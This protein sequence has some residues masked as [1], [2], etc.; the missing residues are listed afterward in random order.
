M[1][2][3]L[4]DID[5]PLYRIAFPVV[6]YAIVAAN[7]AVFGL[8]WLLP[9]QD[10]AALAVALAFQPEG[11]PPGVTAELPFAL[12]EPVGAL[13]ALFVQRDLWH[14]VGNMACLIVFAD[15]VEDAMG[16]LKFLA[17]YLVVGFASSYG[18]ALALE[19]QTVLYGSSGAVSGVIAAYVMLHPNVRLWVLVLM[20]I[21]LRLSAMWIIGA[22]IVYQVVNLVAADPGSNV[23]WA[24][25]VVG[26]LAGALLMP[27]LKHRDVALFD[28]G[29]RTPRPT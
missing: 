11:L 14:L 25:H 29:P 2:L 16:H 7:L 21:P 10:S 1:F 8:L 28:L 4:R 26:L 5:N 12:P 27:V 3:P 17:F 9:A 20:R 6:T 22:W 13:T 18:Q 23:G 24:A 15:N 19:P